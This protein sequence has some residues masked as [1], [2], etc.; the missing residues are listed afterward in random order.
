[1]SRRPRIAVLLVTAVV[2]TVSLQP[3][4]AS[5]TAPSEGLRPSVP[6][7]QWPKFHYDL[8][9]A[10]FNPHET[11]LSPSTVGG[12]QVKW[13]FYL[14]WA[15]LASPAVVDGVVFAA[16]HA[17]RVYA[18]D[19]AT[20]IELWNAT[21]APYPS[22]VSVSD[23]LVFVG[24]GHKDRLFAFDAGTGELRWSFHADGGVRSPLVVGDIVYAGTSSGHVYALRASDG[25]LVWTSFASEIDTGLAADDGHIY[26]GD[27]LGGCVR[28]LN[29]CCGR[30]TSTGEHCFP[31]LCVQL[32]AEPY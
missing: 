3:A 30:F 28:S 25:T 31:S 14:R 18:I 8:A 2:T 9:S 12:L 20:G 7:G 10:G 21:T 29:A 26:A 4:G 27:G 15:S 23:G 32:R 22:D 24:T 6:A 5:G 11:I 16:N 19:A 1:M 13:T 17:G